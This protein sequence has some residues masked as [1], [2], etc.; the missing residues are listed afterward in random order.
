MNNSRIKQNFYTID[1]YKY[2]KIPPEEKERLKEDEYWKYRSYWNVHY[3]LPDGRL[4]AGWGLRY[5]TK[6]TK[7]DLPPDYTYMSNY[8]KHGYIR[9]AGV[10]SLVYKRSSF[11]NHTFKDD[12][13]F[14]SYTKDLGEYVSGFEAGSTYLEADEYIFGNDIIDFIVA[15]DKYSPD[16][17]TTT[18]KQQM[19]EQYNMYCDEMEEPDKKISDFGELL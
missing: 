13:L 4:Y 7:D 16:I 11:H 5:P 10:K 9:T 1:G 8:K 17:D 18:I 15:V 12:F 14:I 3:S 19:V 2:E 6:L